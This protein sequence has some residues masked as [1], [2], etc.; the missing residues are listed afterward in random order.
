[1]KIVIIGGGIAGLTLGI[2]LK[3]KNMNV[4]IC[5]R[6]AGMPSRGHAF[7]MHL[8][9]L[10]ILNELKNGSNI[11]L[12]SKKVDEYVL[13]RPNGQEVKH[14]KLD[15]WHCV[16]RINLINFLYALF[17][18][19]N[20]KE[21]RVFSHFIY[22]DGNVV[23]AAFLNGDVEY[24][25]IFV[26]AD[27]GNSLVRELTLG[28]VKYTPVEVKEIIGITSRKI[29][30]KNPP[31][32]FNKYQDK[33]NGLAFGL[34]PTSESEYVW[35]MQ[36]DPTIA[37]LTNSTAEEINSF[38]LNMLRE[39]PANVTNVIASTDFSNSYIWHTRDFDLLPTFHKKNVVLIGDAA[40]LSLPFTSAGTTNAIL[41]AKTLATCIEDFVSYE[42]AFARYYEIRSAEVKSHIKLGREL[43]KLFLK[44][45]F[46]S[47]DDIPVPL[48]TKKQED[49]EDTGKK[50]IN[51]VY[52]TDPI[53]S[54]CWIIQPM[55][56]KL[57]LE[58]GNYINIEYR[59]GG[60]LPEWE[61]YGKGKINSPSDAAKHWEEVCEEHDMPLDGDIWIEDPLN[62]SYP[63][64]IAFKAA[65][66]QDTDKAIL[67]LRRIKEMVFLE[68]KNIIKW[69]FLEKAALSA[70]LDSA[71]LLR[72][73]EGKAQEL[74]RIDL[75]MAKQLGVTGFPTLFFSNCSEKKFTIKGFQPY[76]KF[77]E[78][79]SHLVPTIKKEP[80]DK[81][82]ES[83][84]NE[85]PT[86]TIK[87][88]AF[89]SDIPIEAAAEILNKLYEEGVVD[90]Y[91]SKNGVIYKNNV[92]TC[93][94]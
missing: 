45:D 64:S 79:I 20:I 63:P 72:D 3:Q 6:T 67:F 31:S 77:E 24:G 40:H 22:E 66:M 47:E 28:K 56:R 43:K 80:I 42:K 89:L 62:S 46:K 87:E 27:G 5:E 94:C 84:F 14:L 76:T 35:F 49:E 19:E 74:F 91:E 81:A 59:M 52:F 25:D 86:M 90:R 37:D 70:G 44:P 61:E 18:N 60:L 73:F 17:P 54:T 51:I 33:S 88:F 29:L 38:C 85:F 13:R 12:K 30:A 68:K 50:I 57:Q 65:Q 10:N 53:C 83:L 21:G 41:D 48:Y 92:F 36:F 4:V 93:A 78:V 39:F 32:I 26:G 16:K 1:M 11:T 75:E 69:E 15:A 23:A 9:G 58:Y 7:L 71:R 55:L 34:I 8:D 2:F 82:P